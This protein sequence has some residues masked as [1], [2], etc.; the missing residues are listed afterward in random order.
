MKKTGAV[1]VAA[2][3]SSRMHDFKPMLPFGNST[4][5]LHNVNLLKQMNLEPIVVVTGHRADELQAHLSSTGVRFRKNE[6]YETTQMFD[7]VKLGIEEIETECERILIMPMDMPAIEKGTFKTVLSIDAPIVRTKYENK[8]GHPIILSIEMAQKFLSY[9]GEN[10]LKGAIRNSGIAPCDV[11]VLDEGIHRD[12]DTPEDYERLI[13]WNYQRGNGYPIRPKVEVGLVA[14]V[15]FFGV[16][17]AALLEEIRK[18]GSRQAACSNLG[19]SYS[20]GTK[21]IKIAENQLGFSLVKRWSGGVEGGG[22]ELTE[23]CENLLGRYKKMTAYVQMA[24]EKAY[25]DFMQY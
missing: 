12:V 21:L 3:M 9:E 24:A 17:T 1:I 14:S 19:L 7:S 10:G 4:I 18:T 2:G 22:S 11:E 8:A 16:E 6:R 25:R 15:G 23:D 13:E 20:K 5:A